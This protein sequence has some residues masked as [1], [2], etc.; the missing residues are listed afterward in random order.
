MKKIKQLKKPTIES[1]SVTIENINLKLLREQ[2]L[3]FL[4][5]FLKIPNNDNIKIKLESILSI[6]D[7]IQDN[8]IAQHGFKESDVYLLS[9]K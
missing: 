2:K 7:A 4:K 3:A 1:C 8:A 9:N 5:V 6:I